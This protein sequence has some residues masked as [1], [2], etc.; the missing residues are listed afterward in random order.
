M[1]PEIESLLRENFEAFVMKVFRSLHDGEKLGPQSYI[2]YLCHELKEVAN[3]N[4]RR[5]VVNLPPRHLKTFLGI[6]L[7]A[8]ILG[9]KP[10]SKILVATYADRLAQDIA[11]KIRQILQL[12]W[13]KTVFKTRIAEDRAKVNDFATLQSGAVSTPPRRADR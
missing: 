12:P 10:S 4:T 7:A 8:W 6:C 2:E 11:Y 3:G 13:Y 9:R 1:K 5:L